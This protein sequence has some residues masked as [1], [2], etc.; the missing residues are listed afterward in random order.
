MR[1]WYTCRCTCRIH[2]R[3]CTAIAVLDVQELIGAPPSRHGFVHSPFSTARPVAQNVS[4]AFIHRRF[5]VVA[6]TVVVASDA[7][8]RFCCA[9]SIGIPPAIAS[10]GERRRDD[11]G[12]DAR[13][14]APY[15]VAGAGGIR[16]AIM[17]II[18]CIMAMW[19]V[20]I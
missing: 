3:A 10:G 9:I 1:A 8:P 7:C 15:L 18:I 17:S 5:S 19:S 12:C 14:G 20:I 16:S 13:D 4:T 11:V 6:K 2:A